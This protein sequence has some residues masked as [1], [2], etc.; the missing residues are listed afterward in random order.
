MNKYKSTESIFSIMVD[1]T[2]DI[3]GKEQESICLRFID[4]NLKAK[5]IFIGVYELANTS[6][7]SIANMIKDVLVRFLK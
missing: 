5:E 6:G 1:G 2:Q 3:M 4:D 7:K